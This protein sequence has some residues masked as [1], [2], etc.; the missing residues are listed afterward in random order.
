MD[1]FSAPKS[2][3]GRRVL[4]A[5]RVLLDMLAAHLARSELTGAD[6]FVFVSPRG[7]PLDYPHWR[8]HVWL[9]ACDHVGLKGLTFH[10]LRSAAATA[11]VL[12]RVDMKTAQARL[13]HSDPRLDARVVRPRVE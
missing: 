8:R 11:L 7:E 2:Q 5:P 12:E 4:S 3:A 13:D 6:A 1:R 10:D 9:P